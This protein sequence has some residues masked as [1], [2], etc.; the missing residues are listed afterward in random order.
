VTFAMSAEGKS[1]ELELR[2][3]LTGVNE[4]VSLPSAG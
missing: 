2:Y 3:L 1:I 4:P